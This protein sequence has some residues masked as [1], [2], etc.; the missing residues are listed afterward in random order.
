VSYG[1]SHQSRPSDATLPERNLVASPPGHRIRWCSLA[2]R[3]P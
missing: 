1:F 3:K 2:G